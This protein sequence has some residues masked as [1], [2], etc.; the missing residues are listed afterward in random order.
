[1][2]RSN[3]KV[4]TYR[5]NKALMAE[6][7]SLKQKIQARL[8]ASKMTSQQLS[9][10]LSDLQSQVGIYKRSEHEASNLDDLSLEQLLRVLVRK[11][12]AFELGKAISRGKAFAKAKRLNEQMAINY[13]GVKR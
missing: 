2:E 3:G 6:I 12:Y 7:E 11:Q 5:F 8:K 13:P 10:Y 9:T 1:M 4:L